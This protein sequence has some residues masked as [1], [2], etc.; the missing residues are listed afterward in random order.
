M[1]LLRA[2]TAV[3]AARTLRTLAATPSATTAVRPFSVSSRRLGGD[4]HG[5]H[6]SPYDPPS[7]YL[8][9]I[10]PGEKHQKEG[11]ENLMFYGFV[12]SCLLLIVALA[13]KPD[14][15]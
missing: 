14:T 15:S 7:G 2:N 5:H 8:F 11:W 1:V 10:K 3:R 9:G 12:P 6:E 4:A 13:F